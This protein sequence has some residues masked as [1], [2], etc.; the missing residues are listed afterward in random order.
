LFYKNFLNSALGFLANE[1]AGRLC[2]VTTLLFIALSC[3]ISDYK[4]AIQWILD[5]LFS[6]EG[7]II[8]G[9]ST[10]VLL[11]LCFRI[12]SFCSDIFVFF[13]PS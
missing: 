6:I 1:E 12:I 8:V 9:L 11:G 5:L 2:S 13:F 10:V 4:S 7:N 3:A